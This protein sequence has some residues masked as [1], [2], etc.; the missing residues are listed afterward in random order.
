ML[1]MRN[2]KR[3]LSRFLACILAASMLLG[4]GAFVPGAPAAAAEPR[5]GG[6]ALT[7][8]VTARYSSNRLN[9][10]GTAGTS[11]TV[12]RSTSPNGLYTQVGTVT[13]PE[14]SG[15]CEYVDQTAETGT[16]YFYRLTD[17]TAPL[18]E[19]VR[20]DYE[21][22][23]YALVKGAAYSR[24]FNGGQLFTS[25]GATD[26]ATDAEVQAVNALGGTG[27]ILLHANNA[28]ATNKT[29]PFLYTND[30]ANYFVG[31]NGVHFRYH[32]GTQ[33]H[34]GAGDVAGHT[35]TGAVSHWGGGYGQWAVNGGDGATNAAAQKQIAHNNDT[36][37]FYDDNNKLF[38]T[39]I[40]SLTLG[41]SNGVPVTVY[42]ALVT[43]ELM[44]D[45]E[46]NALLT[47][48]AAPV[49][50]GVTIHLDGSIA[51]L[52]AGGTVGW[53]SL[54][55]PDAPAGTLALA[56]ASESNNN[57]LFTLGSDGYLKT[58]QALPGD[59][60]YTVELTD[61]V[62]GTTQTFTVHSASAPE[63]G[64][65]KAGYARVTLTW[66][67]EETGLYTIYRAETEEGLATAEALATV[68]DVK[69]YHDETGTGAGPY[70]YR[71]DTQSG[72]QVYPGVAFQA[73]YATGVEALKANAAF[74]KE[75]G[76]VN[77]DGNTVQALTAEE[78]GKVKDLAKGSILIQYRY[79]GSTDSADKNHHILLGMG[80]DTAGNCEAGGNY[81]SYGAIGG[82]MR[83]EWVG[84]LRAYDINLENSATW[85]T[86]ALVDGSSNMFISVNGARGVG[87]SSP[88]WDGF[89]SRVTDP[90]GFG[91][92]GYSAGAPTT[93]NAH[94]CAKWLGKIN[95]VLITDE[96]LTLDQA[97]V[98]TRQE[99]LKV[100]PSLVL[101]SMFTASAGDATWAFTGGA[102]AQGRFSD[103][104][105]ARSYMGEFEE[106]I[107]WTKA[108]STQVGRQ[109]HVMSTARAGQTVQTALESFDTRIAPLDP[110]A[111][112]YLVSQEDWEQGAEG[113]EAFKTG[114]T[115][116]LNKALA[117]KD[118]AALAVV[119]TP[120]APK[121]DEDAAKALAYAEAAKEVVQ[122]LGN[123]RV[124]VV[125][126]FTQTSTDAG[127]KTT[128]LN[129][130]GT[131]NAKGHLELGRQLSLA[132][133]GSDAQYPTND[134]AVAANYPNDLTPVAVPER[135]LT[136]PPTV[137]AGADSLAV[138]IPAEA[139]APQWH[140]VLEVADSFTL[141]GDKTAA[142]DRRFA[143]TDLPA[144]KAYTLTLTAADG[145]LALPVMTGA[146]NDGEAG[147]VKPAAALTGSQQT[148]ANLVKE[149]RP[150]T[151]LFMGDSIT[152]GAK[153]LK[154]YDSISQSVEKFIKE[155]LGRSDDIIIN[156][157]NSG[158]TTQD[159][160]DNLE[161]RLTKFN[162]D[163][164]SIMIGTNDASTAATT[165]DVY[166]ANLRTILS[167]IQAKGAVTIIRTPTPTK[168]TTNNRHTNVPL[169][170][171]DMLD[172]AA[173]F[174]G[175]IVVDQ[176]TYWNEFLEEMPFLW[177]QL[178]GET[179]QYK[180][181]PNPNGQLIM[182]HQFLRDTGLW[183][184]DSA[185]CNLFYD[186]GL[187]S[188]GMD[189]T[190]PVT[191]EGS[192]I[193]L[194]GQELVTL[195][196]A[197][198]GHITLTALDSSGR[199]Y[200]VQGK[201]DSTLTLT[202][203]PQETYSVTA[204]A[205]NAANGTVYT[206][207]SQTVVPGQDIQV[208]FDVLLDQHYPSA[209]LAV[210]AK[211]GG[212]TVSAQAPAGEY[213]FSL[214]T[215]EGDDHNAYFT[216]EGSELKLTQALTGG[217]SYKI[218]VKAAS[219]TH[220][221]ETALTLTAMTQERIFRKENIVI[222][223][224]TT[225]DE[226]DLSGESY[227]E[228]LYHM[229]QGTFIVQ[230]TETVS[231]S[232]LGISDKSLGKNH[233]HFYTGGSYSPRQLGIELRAA[234]NT[235]NSF[236]YGSNNYRIIH[237]SVRDT[238]NNQPKMNTVAFRADATAQTYT[239][240]ANG[241]KILTCEKGDAYK[242]L[243]D[244]E[245]LDSVTL[246]GVYRSN[247][248]SYNSFRGTI[249]YLEVYGAPLS[250]QQL[251]T[252]TG[253]TRDNGQYVFKSGDGAHS[254]YFRIPALTTLGDGQTLI[255]AIDAR[256]GGTEDSANN[257]D[258][259]VA[260]S[261]DGGRTWGEV[262]MPLHFDD[263]A[264]NPQI[265][266]EGSNQKVSNSASFIDPMLTTAVMAD[267]SE[268]VFILVDAYPTGIGTT[269]TQ[270]GS[271]FKE[272]D[273]QKYLALKKTGETAYN[274]TVRAGGVIYEDATG[275]ATEYSVDE[276]YN[277]KQNGSYLTVKQRSYDWNGSA[278]VETVTDIDVKM[279]V[280]YSDAAF[281][282]LP[283]SHLYL[284]HSDDKGAT[285]S[286]PVNLNGMVK[287][288]TMQFF[289]VGPGRGLQI[290][291][292]TYK[293]RIVLPVYEVYGANAKQCR[294]I[295]SD[296]FGETWHRGEAVPRAGITSMTESQVVE[297]PDGT[298]RIFARTESQRV[299][300]AAS[301]DGGETWTN[302][303][304][305]SNLVNTNG[306][307][308]QI[309]VI[310]Y[311]GLI[312][313][314]QALILSSPAGGSRS[315]G[316]IWIG[317]IEEHP[318]AEGADR[319]TVNWTYQ[320]HVNGAGEYFAYSCL[321][322]TP[323]GVGILYEN[324]N[325]KQ[326]IDV[327]RYVDLTLSQLKGHETVDITPEC[328]SE[329]GT[330]GGGG[331]WNVGETAFVSAQAAEGYQ[332]KCW[333]D[334][335]GTVL[336]NDPTY[337]FAAIKDQTVRAVFDAVEPTPSAVIDYSAETLTGL[338]AN[339]SYSITPA[340]GEAIDVAAD[341]TGTIA[342]QP[343]WLA[344]TLSIVKK[345]DGT[346][347][348][349]AP[350]SLSIPARPTAPAAQGENETVQGNEDGKIT[351]LTAGTSYQISS[352][353]GL[354]WT[355]ATL[356][357]TEITNLSAGTYQVR[358]KATGDAFAGEAATVTIGTGAEKI[359]TLTVTVPAFEAVTYGYDQPEAK[360][361]T[362]A[363][364]GNSDATIS[365][366]T[367]SD[368]TKFTIGG[369]GSTVTA[370]SSLATWTIQP[371]AG[372]G[373]GE[374]TDTVTV[375]YN[376]GATATADVSFTVNK[377]TLTLSGASANDKIYD[378][379]TTATGVI[380]L[381]GAVNGEA[382][383]ATGAFAFATA[384]VG[385][386]KAVSVTG[387]TLVEPWG[388]NYTLSP[389]TLNTTAAIT[390]KDITGAT[391][392]LGDA[393]TYTGE[394][395]T[396]TVSS[397]VIDGLT[398]TY[399]V[400]GNTGT[401]AGNYTLTVTGNGNF[402]GTQT[403][404]FTIAKAANS[405]T[406]FTC[407]DII[408]GETPNPS[409]TAL[410]GTDITYTYSKEE[411]GTYGAWSAENHVGTWYVKASVAGTDNYEA[412]EKVVSFKEAP[413]REPTP[414]AAISYITETLTGLTANAGY[415]I[416]PAGGSAVG[417]TA[418]GTGA[419]AIQADW[420]GKDLS[421]VRKAE[422]G[423]F[424]DSTPQTLSIPARP[425]AP[426]VQGEN[427]TFAGEQDGKITGVST[428]MEYSANGTDWT[429]CTSTEV[430]G[431]APGTY[432][433][434]T[435]A[436]DSTFASEAATVTIAAGAERTYTLT[437]TAPTFE[438]VTEG[439][440]QPNAK[441][442]TITST[443]NSDATISG[444]AVSDSTKFTI[445]G[446]GST[447]TAGGS[448]TTWTI[449]PS[450]GL[451][452]GT[453]T[454]TV[455]VTYNGS[456]TATADVSF[457]VNAAAP[458]EYAVTFDS[459]GGSPV[460]SQ[461][462]PSGGKVS[463]PTDPTRE[464]YTFGGWYTEAAYTTLWDFDAGTV[465]GDMTLYAKWNAVTPPD[466]AHVHVWADGWTHND[467][468]H[469]HECTAEGCP[470]TDYS[471]C[472][473]ADAAYAAHTYDDDQDAACN[474]CDYVRTV[475]PLPTQE[476]TPN[477][478]IDYADETLT[479]F[480]LDG[481]YTIDGEAVTPA[482]GAL[483]A[484]GYMGRTISIVKKGDGSTIDSAAQALTVPA[485]PAAP[486]V[487]AV[488]ETAEGA[489]DGKITGVSADMEYSADG[490][491]TWTSCSGTEVTGLAPGAY[492]VR[493]KAT[494]TAFAGEAA[495]VTV[496][497]EDRPAE[498]TVTFDS[499]GG[500][501]VPS[502]TLLSGEQATEPTEPTREG[503]TFGG[504]YTEAACVY[505]WNFER[506][507]T[508]DLTL[509]A[510][511]VE[512]TYGI[513]GVVTD[514]GAGVSG[515]TVTLMQGS[516]EIDSTT[517]DGSGTYS[518]TD[519]APGHY[520]VVATKD[521][522]TITILV[523]IED[524]GVTDADLAMPS[525]TVN[526]VL[527]V[528]GEDTPEVVVGGL[529]QEARENE[530][531]DKTVTVTMTVESKTEDNAANA[532]DL[533]DA[534]GDA[535]SLEF[536]EITVEK[537]VDDGET[538]TTDPIL[539]TSGLLEIIIPF[540]PAGKFD[541]TVYRYHDGQVDVLTEEE[542]EDGEY[543]YIGDTVII[544]HVKNFSTYAVGYASDAPTTYTVTVQTDGNGIASASPA[545]ATAGTEITLT[546]TASS[547][548]LFKE[549][550]VIEGGVTVSN[551]NTFTM[552]AC[553]VTVK[554]IFEAAG[555]GSTDEP[556]ISVTYH[557]I[558]ASAGEGGAIDPS[559][560]VRVRQGGNKTFA[561]TPEE[562]YV[563]ADVLVD[564]E[565]VGAVS[566]YTFERVT[567]AHTIAAIFQKVIDPMTCPKDETCPIHAF[568]DI[569]TTAWYHDGVHYCIENGLMKGASATL[570]AP[571]ADATRATIVTILWRLQGSPVV[572]YAMSYEDVE[573][574][575]WYTEAV[576]WAAS[577]GI[578]IGY[579]NGRFGP[580]DPTTRE[581][582]A[583]MLYR[584]EQKYGGG[585]FTGEWMFLLDFTDRGEVSDWAYEAMCWMTMNHV[586]EGKG[587]KVLDPQGK[588]TRAEVATA[589]AR[590][591]MQK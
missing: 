368:P 46:L 388:D 76:D 80:S 399:T 273:G 60:Q 582:L 8:H 488:N 580:N 208:D 100:E 295:Y 191:T 14:D 79:D 311:D 198:L 129:E 285:W 450:A 429:A 251:L 558:T 106:Y 574:N 323:T 240:F 438:A 586:I 354:N 410:F 475:T 184:D 317:L 243:N 90:T 210:G 398:A 50:S 286:A 342:I 131:L 150:L 84:G 357:G 133:Y 236:D 538:T 562:G 363:S 413:E 120:Y 499:Q 155:D 411:N 140:Y 566:A 338:T 29:V 180:L 284:I 253:E 454:T 440:A 459:R 82:R 149:D 74:Y 384:N 168:N 44:E 569:S 504:W 192:S 298:L 203:L 212:L 432:Q 160:V 43:G 207:L 256:H 309:S 479:G 549:W 141:T 271:G 111:V 416:T 58:A 28:A 389:A 568:S 418:D 70:W 473:E 387:I 336:S 45:E 448:I 196:G 559:G 539:T 402:T 128:C 59:T 65:A 441:A 17:G 314:K 72:G 110:K 292:G 26:S 279:N 109:K 401:N 383:A 334:G 391:V 406:K 105:G 123:I 561:I 560:E 362:I 20:A 195:A 290:K 492:Q 585:G 139:A 352:N 136:T 588:A 325:T 265:I 134:P 171:Q 397:V 5:A 282:A 202:N 377:A 276:Y 518:F 369:S 230:Y 194:E 293:N 347:A 264:D 172:V 170:R 156:T 460:P 216:I 21:T 439:Y 523:T 61:T 513:S 320:Y 242:F 88:S 166:K 510:K 331:N 458:I 527:N 55:G 348:D 121:T 83:F 205:Y 291:T 576:R 590:Y 556:P 48:N 135:H 71:V 116:F 571:N 349:S 221:A 220:E 530:E 437:V 73:D 464:G 443:G 47:A 365:G 75:Y 469:W 554:A 144:G 10:T 507:I 442:L 322:Q 500:D 404:A 185:I 63:P 206:F 567:K 467:G 299:A 526:S 493:T 376:D 232:F 465:T 321:T 385:Q 537:T 476:P 540:D 345:G 23:L 491:S 302:G 51:P 316:R 33:W 489:S 414:S 373:A 548:Y 9:W 85:H 506:A 511:W 95:Y 107:R 306:S 505:R 370:G 446:S 81:F 516:T 235:A 452:A 200:T 327:I 312:D 315:D 233:F 11:Y 266:T 165:R 565:S 102:A 483:P 337:Y 62:S 412:A 300:M 231:G 24:V 407:A 427:E 87:F 117:L 13:A 254:N 40:T 181:H 260:R 174:P 359:Y 132:L 490:G 199:H 130:N 341:G 218:R 328:D 169:Y 495:A 423:D 451:A 462:V 487:T 177:N 94:I 4:T 405:I 572:N 115:Q 426:S 468:Y 583:T 335:E 346:I 108:G 66:P 485:R 522:K 581:Q 6:E 147:L 278:F 400:S 37:N 514:G 289:G 486:S 456:A 262:S 381:A 68:T 307:G 546:A 280:M 64:T 161:Q 162:P 587:N 173:E 16:Q 222:S 360:A 435:G 229:T 474:V 453:H 190:T 367:V 332:F 239:L 283:T 15:S 152:H 428:D 484:A 36:A 54:Q 277:I 536:L 197:A 57:D 234:Q 508:E 7:L 297:M 215:G 478:Q 461:T 313:G 395:Q 355:D 244:I 35:Y 457:T 482:D 22:G 524:A 529:D 176:Y 281:T 543:I 466:P 125:D 49:M 477:I 124:F 340:E 89:L 193:S 248:L 211:V 137:I 579:G 77:F 525:D 103:I 182:T 496:G 575:V 97:N 39:D 512:E 305:V 545:S 154:G 447:V 259:A 258:M 255:A 417:V 142:E 158:A 1:K 67:G 372:L 148:L 287:A 557:V 145:S 502:Q 186:L 364:T 310:N 578:A 396:Q 183:R 326:P 533:Q 564:G 382:P 163:V 515:A 189:Q 209:N 237:G 434:R 201:A 361:L 330:V 217:Q 53:A 318:E 420:F 164:V 379:T 589:I 32:L 249:H 188:Q 353:S 303:A 96:V 159:I 386:N 551:D 509:Y 544:L 563:I 93:T 528:Q 497:T 393:L 138:T 424:S 225:A 92:G 542:N 268:R 122:T 431:L 430:T 380:T 494:D 227:A 127:W 324:F 394:E 358:T 118:G 319:Y 38:F 375:T 308:C 350:Q 339:A 531:A 463:R 275:T 481:R 25:G 444:V 119:Q 56:A 213:T 19:G 498:Y 98:I 274:Y 245:G 204:E 343:E 270:V 449:R 535:V 403:A 390:A 3:A 42:Y 99:T 304:L 532:S 252:M 175:V 146:I 591:I 329:Q 378:G 69:L 366:V 520:N 223:N 250:D 577:E 425:A 247:A 27:T 550:Q 333:Q 157:A 409:A 555:G 167:A 471:A 294:V 415:S 267:G 433:V 91:V 288:D 541:V 30:T 445:G 257:I 187:P 214:A 153:W 501:S 2:H 553:N 179:N 101:S 408:H 521:G 228:Q 104:G 126:H 392:T 114:L 112:V 219:G 41:T 570:F 31:F 534:A 246:G 178:F 422:S 269:L 517:T 272:I 470:I 86:A 519:V 143:I 261:T 78:L 421:I 151:W 356:T 226:R 52:T 18:S 573:Q 455:T 584:Y 238:A 480:A 419:A 371:G 552:P 263:V 472:G 374:Y 351:G 224:A 12:E 503:Y 34:G 113:L 296:D 547:G 301:T 241:E 344:K 436:T